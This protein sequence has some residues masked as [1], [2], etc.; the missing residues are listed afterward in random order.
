MSTQND[1]MPSVQVMQHHEV[2][3]LRWDGASELIRVEGPE[4]A[5]INEW[6]HCNWKWR[7]IE[8]E[9]SHVRNIAKENNA[10][11]H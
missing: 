5:I 4:R 3:E 8:V 11:V 2:A 10:I 6:E 1:A 9:L 7:E